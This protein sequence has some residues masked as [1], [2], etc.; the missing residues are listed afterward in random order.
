MA[1]SVTMMIGHPAFAERDHKWELGG[2]V[3]LHGFADASKLG[4][5][6]ASKPAIRNSVILGARAGYMWKPKLSL[7]VE[8]PPFI[9]TESKSGNATVIVF[10]P[11]AQVALDVFTKKRLQ[12]FAL[13]GAG[14]MI[15][16]S[17]DKTVVGNGIQPQGHVGIGAK[18]DARRGL[19]I[20]ADL[21]LLVLPARGG[22]TVAFE[23]ELLFSLYKTFGGT[24]ATT[25]SLSLED[26]LAK[27]PRGDY[28]SDGIANY[29]DQCPSEPEDIDRVRDKDGCPD[30]DN[31]EDGVPDT[32]DK[33]K[34]EEET[35]NGFEDDDG[36]P[37]EIPQELG[38]FVGTLKGVTF[39]SGST[40][41]TQSSYGILSSVADELLG[42]PSVKVEISGHTDDR[43]DENKN[44]ELSQQRAEAVKNFLTSVAIDP[45]RL[46]A[47]GHGS[48][49]P[50]ADNSTAK[51]RRQNRRVE[52]RL[53]D[54]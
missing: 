9:P 10:N 51:G 26:K 31:D 21:R 32:A 14:A 4:N 33:C 53:L 20:R 43:G 36:C 3:G 23:S 8:L 37:D 48:S 46:T 17:S 39:K 35:P 47:V 25:P 5:D 38:R 1:I 41:L 44:V 6:D 18:Y 15:S 42:Y 11:R 34:Y 40:E 2:F 54:K 7:E 16:L 27:D 45:A 24:R 50:A 29:L 13:V 19:G 22:D 30:P 49:K 52:L 12:P 28:D